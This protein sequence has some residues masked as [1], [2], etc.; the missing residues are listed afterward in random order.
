MDI[1]LLIVKMV[2]KE[3]RRTTSTVFVGIEQTT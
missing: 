2:A 3:K 1:A